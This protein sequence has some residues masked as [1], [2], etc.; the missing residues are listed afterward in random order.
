MAEKA[1]LLS[2]SG[3]LGKHFLEQN[4]IQA[5]SASQKSDLKTSRKVRLK[6]LCKKTSSI[7]T[8][9]LLHKKTESLVP[10]MSLSCNK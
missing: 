6:F 10:E 7:I 9:M 3:R 2:L 8:S 1:V 4:K 5:L